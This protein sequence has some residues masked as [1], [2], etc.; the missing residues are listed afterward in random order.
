MRRARGFK[1]WIIVGIIVIFTL[2]YIYDVISIRLSYKTI[3]ELAD[4]DSKFINVS[5]INIHYKTYGNGDRVFL[6][7]H[8]FSMSTFSFR[9][10]VEPLSKLGKVVVF[11]LPG[12]GLSDRPQRNKFTVN[13]Y[14]REGQVEIT[15][16]LI[17]VLN[18]GKV[19]LVG[20]SMGGTIV[21]ILTIRYPE[22]VDRLVLEDAAIFE[23]GGTPRPLRI[24]FESPMGKFLFPLLV[25]TMVKSLESVIYKAFYDPSKVTAD[26]LEGYKKFLE[27]TNWDKGLYEILIA[28]NNIDFLDKLSEI[29]IPVLVVT[30]KNDIIVPEA[31]SQKLNSILKNSRLVIV[32]SCG[33]I[34]HEEKPDVF[35]DAVRNFVEGTWH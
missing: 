15:K 8:G 13:P 23:T 28:D 7:I 30:G 25:K 19:I 27:V 3:Q 12:F 31:N 2:L 20:H 11:D 34:P 16:Q 32:D 6:L 26:V 18:L 22:M 21:T 17:E 24:F 35:V 9:Y 4:S 5:E 1:K 14:S 33:H 10:I 29:N